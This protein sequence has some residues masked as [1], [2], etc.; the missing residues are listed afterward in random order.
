MG[1]PVV[2]LHADHLHVKLDKAASI[3]TLSGDIVV[4]YST[5][6]AVDVAPPTWPPPFTLWRVGTHM[7]GVVARGRFGDSWRGLRRFLWIDRRT[8]RAL[9]LRLEGHPQY[10]EIVL[11]VR[12]AEDLREGIE[13]RRGKR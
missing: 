4:P 2:T 7:P 11:D 13:A 8:T 5:V 1:T 9:R 10:Q 3:Q 12:D 6:R